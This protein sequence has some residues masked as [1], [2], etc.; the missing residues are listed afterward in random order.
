MNP[1]TLIV[2]LILIGYYTY[3]IAQISL[4]IKNDS[5]KGPEGI[6]K[7]SPK[8]KIDQ[9]SLEKYN[10]D[11]WN[12]I[13]AEWNFYFYLLFQRVNKSEFEELTKKI[14]T[15]QTHVRLSFI[16]LLITLFLNL[17]AW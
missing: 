16:L 11:G 5:F 8:L 15:I 14:E 4:L 2:Y 9:R 3:L 12:L 7:F 10:S 17:I 1:I 13:I 6:R